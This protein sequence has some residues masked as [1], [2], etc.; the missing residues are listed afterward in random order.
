[1]V[2]INL[3]LDQF[4][5]PLDLLLSLIADEKLDIT[6]I[7]LS[8][9]TEQY[10]DYLGQVDEK[11]ANE[12]ADFLVV[13]TRLLLLKSRALLPQLMPEPDDGPSLEAQLR[14]YKIFVDASKKIQKLW[15]SADGG[16]W[17]IEP[18]RRSE[19]FVPPENVSVERL[20]GIMVQLINRLRPPKALPRTVIDKSV[21][22][23]EKIERI[24]SLF[25]QV[26]SL[27]FLEMVNESR[28]RTE[29]IISFMAILELMKQQVVTLSQ[30]DQ[31]GDIVIH[32]L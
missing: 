23:Q 31:F 11:D 9:V 28:S 8:R 13:A 22:I 27:S 15:S 1:M 21:S 2:S 19:V 6:T 18:P 20:R 3:K 14:L 5:G 26:K 10:L 24:R 4:S 30:E 12:L 16:H 29:I 17:R 25:R 7:A 32:R